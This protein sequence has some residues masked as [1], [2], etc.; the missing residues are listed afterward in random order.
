MQLHDI[1]W[2]TE[3]NM[4]TLDIHVDVDEQGRVFY[5]TVPEHFK[6]K[7]L[8]E[9]WNF[10][11]DPAQRARMLSHPKMIELYEKVKL[12]DGSLRY[13]LPRGWYCEPGVTD[14]LMTHRA[15]ALCVLDTLADELYDYQFKAVEA[16]INT[17]WTTYGWLIVSDTGTGK[18]RMIRALAKCME[19]PIVFVTPNITIQTNAVN[20]FAE[21]GMELIPINWLQDEIDP[22]KSYACHYKTLDMNY[23]KLNDWHRI[24]I[25]DEA[26]ICPC[27][28]LLRA[29]CLWR[30][31]EPRTCVFWVTATPYRQEF[32]QD[33]FIKIF[34][35]MY[36]TWAKALPL[37]VIRLKRN[38][39]YDVSYMMKCKWDLPTDSYE[40]Y[41]NMLNNDEARTQEIVD[42]A[43][44]CYHKGENWKV[45]IFTD[46]VEYAKH[47]YE[48]IEK[49]IWQDARL[50][51]WE[52]SKQDLQNSLAKSK[53]YIIVWTVGC[54]WEWLD[55]PALTTW[56]LTFNTSN[57]KV[58]A[59]VAWRMRRNFEGKEYWF[60]IDYADIIQV[61]WWKKYYGWISKRAN[62]Y[63]ELGFT[64]Q[65]I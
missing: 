35:T 48:I 59:Q 44:K 17:I 58:L 2:L 31:D 42:M 22:T 46:R 4:A 49:E 47:L 57:Q 3:N 30:N 45:L 19:R 18:T 51:I 28:T 63:E 53:Q 55:L 38:R 32:K 11:K 52:T 29:I 39:S 16:M 21:R 12:P 25:C 56:I 10:I 9:V 1:I 61:G 5:D 60:L 15:W 50:H 54:C 23:D 13:Y 64:L 33:W 14:R 40:I 41:R 20:S 8:R 36:E 26:H 37:H 24:L 34:W 43:L 62:I 27:D 7:D 65:D 6:I